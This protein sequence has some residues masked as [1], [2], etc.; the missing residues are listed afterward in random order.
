MSV[1]NANSDREQT[2][3]LSSAEEEQEEE[4]VEQRLEELADEISRVIEACPVREK[5]ALHDYAVSLVRERAPARPKGAES[6]PLT[7]NPGDHS[8]GGAARAGIGY[9]LM[10]IP[11]G[12]VIS[13]VIPPIGVLLMIAGAVLMVSGLFAVLFSGPR[14]GRRTSDD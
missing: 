2:R 10:L 3:E 14:S 5:D 13:P 9:G 7:E 12:F 6:G 4:S 11:V 8:A 1:S